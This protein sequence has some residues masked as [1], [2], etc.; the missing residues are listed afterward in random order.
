LK[1]GAIRVGQ[2][3]TSTIWTATRK[4]NS[5]SHQRGPVNRMNP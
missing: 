5:Q 4:A 3:H 1:S 2:A